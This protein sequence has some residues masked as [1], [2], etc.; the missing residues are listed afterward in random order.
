MDK[1]T[2]HHLQNLAFGKAVKNKDGSISTVATRQFETPDGVIVVP[3]VFDGKILGPREAMDRAMKE[4][5][6]EKFATLDEADAFDRK[7]H[8]NND[9]LG[10]KMMPISAAEA[11]AILEKFNPVTDGLLSNPPPPSGSLLF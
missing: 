5:V 10:G 6:F 11:L 9:A 3:S 8:E 7:I 1:I 2:K 4:G